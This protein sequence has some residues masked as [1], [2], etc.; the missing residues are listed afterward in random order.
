[1]TVMTA[2]VLLTM[3][4]FGA[5]ISATAGGNVAVN[6]ASGGSVMGGWQAD[7]FSVGRTR[8][9]ATDLTSVGEFSGVP[10][11]GVILGSSGGAAKLTNDG[12][13]G[14]LSDRAVASSPFFLSNNTSIVNNSGGT[15]TGFT[16]L[17]GGD[18]SILNNGTFNLRHFADTTG[19]T[20]ANGNGVRD[21]L[22]VATADLGAQIQITP[23]ITLEIRWIFTLRAFQ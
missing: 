18:N 17:V 1:M 14:A 16:Q 10:A 3:G 15:I 2:D 19:L 6:V 8:V 23:S 7:L 13:I 11:A 5:A 21:T 4:Q 12:S 20:D 9:P 22:R